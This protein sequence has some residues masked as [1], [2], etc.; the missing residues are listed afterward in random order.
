MA[1]A[2]SQFLPSLEATNWVGTIV[3]AGI[4]LP[5]K[6]VRSAMTCRIQFGVVYGND[7]KNVHCSGSPISGLTNT[8]A[9]SVRVR[10]GDNAEAAFS[11]FIGSPAPVEWPRTNKTAQASVDGKK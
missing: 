3:S 5:K 8:L 11:L 1:T 7:W 6:A 10:N 9:D 4:S 2:Q